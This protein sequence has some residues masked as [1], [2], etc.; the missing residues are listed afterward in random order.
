MKGGVTCQVL[1]IKEIFSCESDSRIANDCLSVNLS[2]C[3]QNPSASQIH[4]Y[5]P[6][7]ASAIYQPSCILHIS[8]H[9][10]Y[11]AYELYSLIELLGGTYNKNPLV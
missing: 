11:N 6:L 9:S 3:Y 2:V 10:A 1:W 5:Q 4:A 7:L 8:H